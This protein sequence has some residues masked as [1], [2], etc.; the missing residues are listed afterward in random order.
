MKT[1][2]RLTIQ[3]YEARLIKQIFRL[4]YLSTF[5][6]LVH[7]REKILPDQK[8]PNLSIIKNWYF[9]LLSL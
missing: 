8:E 3:D 2:S 6:G 5:A 1:P 4:C 7:T 9:V